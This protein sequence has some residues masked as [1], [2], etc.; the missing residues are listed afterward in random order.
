[1][2]QGAVFN[3]ILNE[4]GSVSQLG[5]DGHVFSDR[6]LLLKM[7]DDAH[8][9]GLRGIRRPHRHTSDVLDG[10]FKIVL[11]F[12]GSVGQLEKFQFLAA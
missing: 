5:E 10:R 8:L 4:Q 6:D 11:L 3:E 9:P 12:F 1:V 7:K 2:N